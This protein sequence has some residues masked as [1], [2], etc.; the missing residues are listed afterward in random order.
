MEMNDD[1]GPAFSPDNLFHDPLAEVTNIEHV[2]RLPMLKTPKRVTTPPSPARSLAE[3]RIG[4]DDAL[5]Q[6]SRDLQLLVQK[7]PTRKPDYES[8]FG[9]NPGPEGFIHPG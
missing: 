7:A 8:P 5:A 4:R 1:Q 6:V 3:R 2:L 9:V